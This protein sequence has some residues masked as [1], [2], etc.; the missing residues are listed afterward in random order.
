M[1]AGNVLHVAGEKTLELGDVSVFEGRVHD[2]Q[3]RKLLTGNLK[4]W[5]SHTLP[6]L[7]DFSD[8]PPV[9][10]KTLDDRNALSPIVRALRKSTFDM[11]KTSDDSVAA[12]GWLADDFPGCQGHFPG[13]PVLPAVVMVLW[14]RILGQ[15]LSATTL[16]PTAISR[17][18]F[19][20]I[21]GPGVVLSLDLKMSRQENGLFKASF[22]ITADHGMI[23]RIECTWQQ[24]E[25]AQ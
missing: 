6:A 18:K 1:Q 16:T 15:E 13:Y 5:E 12:Q 20:S 23:A 22:K 2:E 11:K 17:A 19:G 4:V 8:K 7:P 3:N 24:M 10:E 9:A 14:G 25:G 21:A